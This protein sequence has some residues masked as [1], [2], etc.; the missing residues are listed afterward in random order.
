MSSVEEVVSQYY[1]Y[2]KER[3]LEG[4]HGILSPDIVVTYHSQPEQFPWSGQFHGIQGF[5]RFFDIIKSHLDVVEVE[6]T[7]STSGQDRVVNQCRG[8]WQYKESGYRV[9]GSMVNVFTIADG[10]I[11]GYDVYADTAAFAAGYSS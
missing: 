4:L 9:T 8:T 2:L 1:K 6:I 11:S 5:D 10:K 3:D 7:A